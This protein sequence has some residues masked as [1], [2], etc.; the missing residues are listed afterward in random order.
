VG[1]FKL[2][3]LSAGGFPG[4]IFSGF[5][6][7]SCSGEGL[8]SSAAWPG[9]RPPLLIIGRCWW[10]EIVLTGVAFTS[11]PSARAIEDQGYAIALWQAPD[12]GL[13]AE[14][15]AKIIPGG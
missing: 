1:I 14:Q 5:K 12:G 8:V 3:V 15:P 13:R 9:A 4:P 2:I 7:A 6:R 10:G 11:I